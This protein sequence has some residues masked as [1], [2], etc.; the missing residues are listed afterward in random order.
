M[1]GASFCKWVKAFKGECESITDDSRS[2]RSVD[3]SNPES[4]QAIED[5]IRFDRRV[6]LE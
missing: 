2:G 4:V 1:F 3:V 6:S 5:M